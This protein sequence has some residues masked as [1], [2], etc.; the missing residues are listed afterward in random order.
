MSKKNIFKM[1]ETKIDMKKVAANGGK[2]A[3]FRPTNDI[4]PVPGD[5][6]LAN[7]GDDPIAVQPIQYCVIGG[8]FY[9]GYRI[10]A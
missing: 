9:E 2:E 10:M 4:P 8:R 1:M 5:V 6:I 7:D 3:C